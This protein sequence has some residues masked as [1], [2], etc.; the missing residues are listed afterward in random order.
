MTGMEYLERL[1]RQGASKPGLSRIR[2]L[3][4]RL[5]DPQHKIQCVHVAGTNGKGSTCVFLESILRASGYRTGAFLSPHL[6]SIREYIRLD[7]EI[8]PEDLF[9][10]YAG[11]IMD[12]CLAIGQSDGDAPTF[13]EAVTALAFHAFDI[14][15]VDIAV[16]ET[17]M[18]GTLDATNV[19]DPL[20]SVITPVDLDHT[21]YLGGTIEQIAAH[22]AGIIKPGRPAVIAPQGHGAA[23][24]VLLE[25]AHA[26][27]SRV[28]DA[29]GCTVQIESARLDGTKFSM[30]CAQSRRYYQISLP[31]RHQVQN[32]AAAVL[33]AR[34]F[35]ELGFLQITNRSI[36]RGLRTAKWP[37]RL[38][39]ARGDVNFI[40]DG[41]HNPHGAKALADFMAEQLPGENIVLVC[42]LLGTKDA[43]GIVR[44]FARFSREAVLTTPE[45]AHAL[46]PRELRGVFEENGFGIHVEER[47]GEAVRLAARLAGSGGWVVVS[48]S[49]Y[50]LGAARGML[51]SAACYP[52]SRI[53]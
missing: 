2:T 51:E 44:E 19:I 16:I 14:E 9:E 53:V 15:G 46:N 24:A 42:G 49:L 40:F 11:R 22:K 1:Y 7:G 17:G 25:R 12:E 8:C 27:G 29:V 4:A 10:Q 48:G 3:L 26:L 13:F 37:G 21:A 23:R 33:A 35:K 38:E 43:A 39:I 18:G 47:P 41:A 45:H 5:D 28:I 6:V 31:G 50:L 52:H 20:L 30:E 32:A 36:S 34:C